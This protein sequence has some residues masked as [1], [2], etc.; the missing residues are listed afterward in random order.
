MA[1]CWRPLGRVNAF[2]V[3]P[4]CVVWQMCVYPLLFKEAL[5]H[6]E[7]HSELHR[8]L[9]NA[10]QSVTATV[11]QVNERVRATSEMQHMAG[12]HR[13]RPL[14]RCTAHAHAAV[15]RRRHL[16]H[17]VARCCTLLHVCASSRV[18]T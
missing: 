15:D 11:T 9:T 8:R 12:A 7:E 14:R 16:L 10:F 17:A 6:A 4:L 18:Q 2:G 13:H 5:K 3:R 1:L